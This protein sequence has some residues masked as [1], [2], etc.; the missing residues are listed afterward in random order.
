M[1]TTAGVRA[2]SGTH[3]PERTGEYPG[4]R[5][6]R[7]DADHGGAS[8]GL[9]ELLDRANSAVYVI[10]GYNRANHDNVHEIFADLQPDAQ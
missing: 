9:R 6:A 2:G 1:N 5:A 8:P 3:G 10:S 4:S 7:M